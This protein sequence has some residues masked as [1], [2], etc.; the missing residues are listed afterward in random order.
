MS[1]PSWAGP[2]V[3]A[4]LEGLTPGDPDGHLAHNL[5]LVRSGRKS[6]AAGIRRCPDCDKPFIDDSSGLAHCPDCRLYRRRRCDACR[7]SIVNT[8]AGDRLC[9]SCREQTTLFDIDTNP[10][11][12]Q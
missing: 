8:A 9:E 1:E 2:I 11:A 5:M 3:N 12:A 7:A 6:R 4:F 10:G